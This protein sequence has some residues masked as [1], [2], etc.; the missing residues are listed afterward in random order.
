MGRNV[1]RH[2]TGQSLERTVG[3]NGQVIFKIPA[4]KKFRFPIVEASLAVAAFLALQIPLHSYI[5]DDAYIHLTFARNIASGEGFSFNPGIPTYGVTSPLWTLLLAALGT[6]FHT[7]IITAK[8][9]SI[10]FGALTI[11]MMF[12]L[13]AQMGMN[14][15]AAAT[16]MIVWAVNVWLVRWSAS[17]ME[18]SLAVFLILS[19]VSFQLKRSSLS[20]LFYGLSILTRPES[21]ILLAILLIDYFMTGFRKQALKAL[22]LSLLVVLPWFIYTIFTFDSIFPN[23]ARVK[24]EAGL[25]RWEDFLLG[26]KRTV[27]I[28]GGSHGIEILVLVTGLAIAIRNKILMPDRVIWL[29]TFLLLWSIFPSIFYL[30]RGVFITSR[31][32][33][34]GIPAILLGAFLTLD[35][36]SK[37]FPALNWKGLW[38]LIFIVFFAVQLFLTAR[39]TVPHAYTFDKTMDALRE[40]AEYIHKNTPDDS[41]VAVGDVGMMGYA[42]G[43]YILDLEGLVTHEMI[44]N[45]VGQ[46]LD[47]VIYNEKYFGAPFPNYIVDKSKSPNRLN[48]YFGDRYRNLMVIAI[49]GGLIDNADEE[50]RYTLYRISKDGS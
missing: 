26:L 23:P 39:I 10:L 31:Y 12:L 6:I 14:R 27:I 16:V 19:G 32:L 8:T 2:R 4:G 1:S 41:V 22:I 37:R 45:R 49:P 50:W 18:S 29:A 20:G 47:E 11:P 15:K 40:I 46:P 5:V 33:L 25:P 21:G 24:A 13:A 36:F 17:G 3:S 7:S 35:W 42:S 28:I 44:P 48:E 9:L 34:I 43:R 38:Q 30:S